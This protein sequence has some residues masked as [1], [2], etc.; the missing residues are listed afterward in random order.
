MRAIALTLAVVGPLLAWAA[1]LLPLMPEASTGQAAWGALWLGLSVWGAV[2]VRGELPKWR[3]RAMYTWTF[4]HLLLG[5]G[6][7]LAMLGASR[8]PEKRALDG[9]AFYFFENDWSPGAGRLFVQVRN[10]GAWLMGP[11]KIIPQCSIEQV[12]LVSKSPRIG[13]LCAGEV[14]AW[15]EPKQGRW[16]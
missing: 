8:A 9:T 4:G 13:V 15:Y 5:G 2:R 11:Q 7:I 16:R 10:E 1:L 3:R 12:S 14:R 6:V